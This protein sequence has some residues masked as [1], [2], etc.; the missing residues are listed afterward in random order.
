MIFCCNAATKDTVMVNLAN[1]SAVRGS[2][3]FSGL[4]ESAAKLI[5][6]TARTQRFAKRAKLLGEGE[7][8]KFL[9]IVLDGLVGLFATHNGGE[10]TIEVKGHGSVLFLAAVMLNEVSLTSVRTLA[11]SQ[12]VVIPARHV[13]DCCEREPAIARAVIKSLAQ[14]FK[15]TERALKNMKL[16]SST[17]RLANWLLQVE[18]DSGG[19]IVLPFDKRTLASC[20]GMSAENLSRNLRTLTKYGVRNSGQKIIIEDRPALLEFAKPNALID[21]HRAAGSPGTAFDPCQCGSNPSS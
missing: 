2:P 6:E 13:R 16:R 14:Q 18:H 5:L 4:C 21:A 7:K 11:P 9:L 10:T 3:L 19:C 17:E 15:C 8:P 12:I 20:L 1:L